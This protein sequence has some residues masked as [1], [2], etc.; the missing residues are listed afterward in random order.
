MRDASDHSRCE[1]DVGI[2][3]TRGWGSAH[4][5]Y[6]PWTTR[7][8]LRAARG[9]PAIEGTPA[10]EATREDVSRDP[11]FPCGSSGVAEE[12]GLA[13]SGGGYRATLFHLGALWRLNELGWLRAVDRISAVSG[14]SLM[15]GIL[16]TRW[17]DLD[18]S[19]ANS[20]A[21]NF[22]EQIVEPTLAFTGLRIDA[23]VIAAGLVPFVNPASVMD[24]VLHWTLTRRKSLGEIPET[25]RFV[26]N[27][28]NLA[29]GVTWRFSR[30]Y[31][32]DS[33][34]GV[35]CA[36]AL[37]LSRAIA[38]SAAYPPFVAPLVLD[39]CRATIQDVPG[40]DLFATPEGQRLKHSVRLLD[41]GAYDN[42]G[43][44]SVEGR[45]RIVF[46]SDA[47]GNLSV[48]PRTWRYRFWWPL[49]R[50]TLDLAVEVGRRQRRR[51]LIDRAE[52]GQALVAAGQ[53]NPFVTERVAIWRTAQR[54][55]GHPRLPSGWVVH[56]AW[57]AYLAGL[58]TRMWPMRDNDRKALVNW[59]YLTSDLALRTW[60]PGLRDA[61]P[62]ST[63]PFNDVSFA[64]APQLGDGGASSRG[65]RQNG[66][67]AKRTASQRHGAD[68][69]GI[70]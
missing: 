30:Q 58:P 59:G 39:L 4:L 12:V 37:R 24:R 10:I 45:C 35:V 22:R 55:S 60:I 20:V 33:R 8:A 42:L 19:D 43:V 54:I 17:Q 38:A 57:P 6:R 44:E 29:T 65:K 51:A 23:C 66:S 3:Q 46:A 2:G 18:W 5:S 56:Q 15:A 52:A 63:L 36:P 21:Q 47:G 9:H 62:P 32:G 68:E 31:M 41:G 26:F 28:A 34:I 13:L 27:S 49:V 48:D 50:R 69:R 16:A 25:P 53:P 11:G 14:G 40:A 64:R 67:G 1:L 70:R 61:D 7:L